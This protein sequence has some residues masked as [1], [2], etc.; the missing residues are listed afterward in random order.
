MTTKTESSFNVQKVPLASELL[1]AKKPAAK[2]THPSTAD[3]VTTAIR[4]LDERGGS[5]LHA[6]KKYIS[7][8]YMVDTDKMGP[9]IK[10]FI[11]S[12]VTK[13]LLIQTKGI[14]AA[15]SFKLAP[16]KA[17]KTKKKLTA[18]KKPTKKSAGEKRAEET[19]DEAQSP[20]K[21][22]T[23]KPTA[24]E[25]ANDAQSPAKKATKKQAAKEVANDAQSPAKKATKKQAAKKTDEA[26]APGEKRTKKTADDAQSPPKKVVKKPAAKK[27]ADEPKAPVEKA[28]KKPKSVKKI[29]DEAE[30]PKK[31]TAASP[32]TK[33][34]MKTIT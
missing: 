27:T 7:V 25:V 17:S 19:A 12:A 34:A 6:I 29:S 4:I 13:G 31:K 10:K 8:T 26:E 24:K 11:K 33:K 3:M 22:N 1:V 21:K 30:S 18:A 20:A 15:G 2:A 28:A 16:E 14:G 32:K 9:F 5:S 23:K